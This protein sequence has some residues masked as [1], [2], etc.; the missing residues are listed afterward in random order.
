MSSKEY[1]KKRNFKATPEP[2]NRGP[3]SAER[4]FVVQEHHARHLHYDFRLEAFG[5]L[6]SWA[7]PKGVPTTV[8]EKRLAVEVEDHPLSYATFKGRIPEGN[9]GAGLVKVWDTGT[10][11]SL[12]PL[13]KSFADG[14]IEI[15]MTGKKLKGRWILIRS[16]NNSSK[17]NQWLLIKGHTKAIQVVPKQTHRAGTRTAF[18]TDIKP[19]LAVLVERAPEGMEYLHEIKLD[20][21]RTLAFIHSKNIQMRT[22]SSLDW[23][24]KYSAIVTELKK[25]KLQNAILDGEIIVRDSAGRSS[26]SELQ[27]A[28]SEEGGEN[29]EYCVFDLLYLN[30]R[31]LREEPLEDRKELLQKFLKTKTLHN[32]SYV[33]HIL[34]RGIELLEQAREEGLE[35]IIAKDRKAVYSMTRHPSW[36]KIKCIQRQ[37]F[38]IGGYTDPGGARHGFGA[39]LLGVFDDGQLRFVGK[40]GTGFNDSVLDE[41][42]NKMKK[43]EASHSYFSVSSPK[44]KNIHWL[45]P[46]LVAEIEFRAWTG[47]GNIRQG[48]FVALRDD[49]SA[50]A[51]KKEQPLKIKNLGQMKENQK[52]KLTITNPERILYVKDKITKL[53]IANY[54]NSVSPWLLKYAGNRPLS[55]LRCM[56]STSSGCFFQKHNNSKTPDVYEG[57]VRDQEY[58][59]TESKKGLMQLIQSGAVEIHLWQSSHAKPN[60]PD[61]IIFDLDPDEAVPWRKIVSSAFLLRDTL[62]RLGLKSFV[63]T[64]GGKGLHIQVPIVAKYSFEQVKNF[65]KTLCRF[66]ES[67]NS[68]LYTTNMAKKTR[69]KKIFLD[70]LRNGFGATAVA[71]FSVRAKEAPYVAVPISW[72]ELKRMKQKKNFRIN[73]VL[74]RLAIQKKDPWL[75]YGKLKQRIRALEKGPS[76]ERARHRGEN[77]HY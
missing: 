60:N 63:K 20:G 10:W 67:E 62:A 5:T 39:I 32:V 51:I 47:D 50:K 58:F 23:S 55:V 53:D 6:K 64:T 57:K 22:R 19:Q 11:I 73:D 71:P 14:K 77:A 54:Y 38:V 59:H 46:E 41:L 8:G 17:Q 65:A 43:Y 70:Y 30:G 40:V 33:E 2:K 44:G 75:G 69:S 9:Y 1:L 24:H 72:L 3:K 74:K 31:D 28:L 25:L 56:D 48:S 52:S 66:L 49:K 12:K 35:G 15:E 68:E 61:Q 13:K 7:L 18:P 26:F 29:L 21:Y 34:G 76:P 27:K 4:I 16:K 42:Y 45:R 36:L 37:E